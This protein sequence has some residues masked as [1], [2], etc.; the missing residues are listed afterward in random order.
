MGL[1][2]YTAAGGEGDDSVGIARRCQGDSYGRVLELLGEVGRGPCF[3]DVAE[4][5]VGGLSD[6]EGLVA[7]DEAHE[8]KW[9]GF[10]VQFGYVLG[11]DVVVV[12]EEIFIRSQKGNTTFAYKLR[13]RCKEK[14][15][16]NRIMYSCSFWEFSW[17]GPSSNQILICT[18]REELWYL[19]LAWS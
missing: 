4:R 1:A 17:N 11:V 14:R 18:H 3:A 12:V 13:Y 16:Y 9:C 5:R 7:G 6:Y 10:L 15:T 8:L 19:V 2:E